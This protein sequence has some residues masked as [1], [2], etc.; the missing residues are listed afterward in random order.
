MQKN[1]N[2]D[3]HMEQPLMSTGT[4]IAG[5]EMDVKK[6]KPTTKPKIGETIIGDD[7]K[8]VSE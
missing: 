2:N 8:Q 3:E 7:G 5:F 4:T 1:E 6:S